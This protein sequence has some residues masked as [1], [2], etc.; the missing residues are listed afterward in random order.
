MPRWFKITLFVL[1]PF[2]LA[3]LGFSVVKLLN[4][5]N[6][7]RA[8]AVQECISLS[9]Y[10]HWVPSARQTL[11]EFCAETQWSYENDLAHRR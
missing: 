4:H 7:H 1:S 9:G 8:E 11:E 10:G 3:A 6:E 5:P 2:I